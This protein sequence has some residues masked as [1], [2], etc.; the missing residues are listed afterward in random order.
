MKQASEKK[1]K[2]KKMT[3]FLLPPVAA[4]VESSE[5]GKGEG[6]RQWKGF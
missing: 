6:E 3:Q 5:K 1:K 2:K 4:R